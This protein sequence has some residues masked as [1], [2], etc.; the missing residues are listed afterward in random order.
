MILVFLC[1]ISAFVSCSANQKAIIVTPEAQHRTKVWILERYQH[2]EHPLIS[3]LFTRTIERLSPGIESLKPHYSLKSPVRLYVISSQEISTFSLC[4]G[5]IFITNSMIS[6]LPN[7]EHFMAIIS[8][9]LA[10]ILRND[11][12][13]ISNNEEDELNKEIAADSLGAKIQYASYIDPESALQTLSISYRNF[14]SDD[15]KKLKESME[16]RKKELGNTLSR[17]PRINT[18]IPEERIYRKVKSLLHRKK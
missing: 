1:T 17:L 4:D 5:S 16:I 18:K 14:K 3:E 12:C 7:A 10:H 6:A 13:E 15:S 9:E 11:A 8:H 2:I